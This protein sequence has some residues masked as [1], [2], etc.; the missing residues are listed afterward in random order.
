MRCSKK[1]RSIRSIKNQKRINVLKK[2][3]Q[4]VESA[5]SK[6]PSLRE[7]LNHKS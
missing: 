2:Q 5:L 3:V 1:C 4:N 6:Y 7:V